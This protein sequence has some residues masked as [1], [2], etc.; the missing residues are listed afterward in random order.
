MWDKR[1]TDLPRDSSGA[2]WSRAWTCRGLER[3]KRE[4]QIQL[5]P[6]KLSRVAPHGNASYVLVK[7]RSRAVC[8]LP[9]DS[10]TSRHLGFKQGRR[11]VAR[12]EQRVNK[13][14]GYTYRTGLFSVLSLSL[15]LSWA[16][17]ARPQPLHTH[18]HTLQWFSCQMFLTENRRLK[19]LKI[20]NDSWTCLYE[21]T[22]H[23]RILASGLHRRAK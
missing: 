13:C 23:T 1:W 2:F 21:M 19:A 6:R 12:G 3:L 5:S 7:G 8:L 10:G 22:K 16:Q 9:V 15:S 11:E 4:R 14:T 20:I 17:S 18:T